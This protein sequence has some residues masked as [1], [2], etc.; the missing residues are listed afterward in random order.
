LRCTGRVGVTRDT[1]GEGGVEILE[2]EDTPKGDG[3]NSERR[4]R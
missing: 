4:A 3:V 2:E 1:T